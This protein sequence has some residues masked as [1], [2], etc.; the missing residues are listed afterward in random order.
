M[1]LT[2]IKDVAIRYSMSPQTFYRWH[3]YGR[4]PQLFA[5]LGKVLFVNESELRKMAKE[6]KGKPM[7]SKGGT[8]LTD[9]VNQ[10]V[11]DESNS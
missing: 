5:K 9:K 11:K 10:K 2:R 8:I 7:G 1:Q 4:F 6:D 3:C